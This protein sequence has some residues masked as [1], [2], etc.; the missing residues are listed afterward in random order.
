MTIGE[1]ARRETWRHVGQKLQAKGS[2]NERRSIRCS[3]RLAKLFGGG[4][5]SIVAF[6]G[7][8]VTLHAP[9]DKALFGLTLVLAPECILIKA[10]RAGFK[11]DEWRGKRASQLMPFAFMKSCS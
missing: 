7:T 9:T 1:I 10:C 2:R 5:Q 11:L 3:R 4:G 8:E 6:F